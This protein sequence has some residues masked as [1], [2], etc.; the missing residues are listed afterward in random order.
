MLIKY[1]PMERAVGV[2]ILSAFLVFLM[3]VIFVGRGQNWFKVRHDYFAIYKEG[4]SLQPGTKVKLLKTD[5]GQVTG[6]ELTENNKVK[7]SFSILAEYASKIRGDSR[8]A[9]ESPTL[10]GSEFV[11]IVPGSMDYPIIPAGG[12][13][14]SQEQ[15][16]IADYLEEIDFEHKVLLIDEILEN[17]S[18]ITRQIQDPE[19]G[20]FGTLHN[21]RT[22]TGIIAR[23]EGSLGGL[24][25]QDEFYRK[26]MTEMKVVED[27]LSSI[28]KTAEQVGTGAK[29]VRSASDFLDKGSRSIDKIIAGLEG[30]VPDLTADIALVLARLDNISRDLEKAMRNAP[31]ISREARDGIREVNIILDSVK[32]N[33]LVRPNLP[34]QPQPERHGVEIRGD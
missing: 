27:I 16:K 6:V 12:Q 15:K 29:N 30:S 26:I 9:I 5:I 21:I 17:I 20:L 33:F 14:P 4:Y 34:R 10:I 28:S 25:V 8:A 2:F 18:F 3:T 11:A 19:G 32:K 24:V 7:V 23:G 22:L 31:E 1:S 13:I